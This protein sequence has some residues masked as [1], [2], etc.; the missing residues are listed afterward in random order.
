M[1]AQA[2]PLQE[3]ASE[4]GDAGGVGAPNLV[5]IEWIACNACG[6]DSFEHLS[7]VGEW[8]IGRCRG[9]GLVYV[10]P[11]PFFE[12]TKSFSRLSLD[13]QYTRFQHVIRRETLEHERAQM[14]AQFE[15]LTELAGRVRS[16]GRMLDVGCGSGTSVRAAAEVGWDAIGIDIDPDLIELGRHE[17]EVDL[18]CCSVMEL[19]ERE[20]SFDFVRM[21][22]VIEHLPNPYNAL[23]RIGQLL[24]PGGTLLVATPNEGSLAAQLRLLLGGRRDRIATVPPPHHLHGFSPPTLRRLFDRVALRAR[25]IFTTTPVDPR[26]VTARNMSAAGERLRSGFW[27]AAQGLGRGSMLVGWAQKV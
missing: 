12:P 1:L 21:R 9:C 18:R 6:A 15:K 3:H 8:Q 19:N 7:R 2:R 20:G 13:F 24:R 17:L 4:Q 11:T 14:R 26:Y 10:N 23:L 16:G 5:R 25:E 27:H 22:D